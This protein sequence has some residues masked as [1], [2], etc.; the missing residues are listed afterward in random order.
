MRQYAMGRARGPAKAMADAIEPLEPRCMLSFAPVG[1]EI[2]VN[3]FTTSIQ[4]TPAIAV[5]DSGEFVVVWASYGQD[6]SYDGVYAQRYKPAGAPLG[7]EFR[8][9]TTTEGNQHRPAV[10]LD[11]DGDF[12]IVW[13]SLDDESTYGIFAQRF[14]PAG[15]P[16]GSEVLV[17]SYTSS[18]QQYS[19]VAVDGAGNFVVVW[20][21]YGQDGGQYGIYARRYDS[22]GAAQGSEFR[23]NSYT[24]GMQY[25]PDVAMNAAGDFVVTWQSYHQDGDGYGI[26]AKRYNAAGVEQ[27]PPAGAAPG[28]GNEFRVNTFTSSHQRTPSIAM[29]NAGKFAVTWV[30]FDQLVML[31][32][33]IYAQ[34]FDASGMPQGSEFRVNTYTQG[35]QFDPEVAMDNDGDALVVWAGGYDQDGDTYGVFGCRFNATGLRQDGSDFQINTYTIGF[36]RSPT[37]GMTADRNAVVAWSST[38]QDGD[39]YG[40]YAQRYEES[41]A[42]TPQVTAAEFAFD[43]FPQKL[44]FTFDTDASGAVNAGS[45]LLEKIGGGAVPGLTMLPYGTDGTNVATFT[46][47]SSLADGNYQA[48]VSDVGGA[49]VLSFFMLSGDANHDRKV[50]LY[51]LVVIATNWQGTGKTFAQGDFDYN[52]VVN[53]ADL[54]ILATHWQQKLDMPLPNSPILTSARRPTSRS[55]VRITTMTSQLL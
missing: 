20:A 1:G 46:M 11:S 53:S 36:Q 3:T 8:V 52:G 32:S 12:V 29:D 34:R 15:D 27:T 19:A 39:D 25:E 51:D 33:E 31:D 41:A 4:S 26:F 30:G 6:G 23:V 7:S 49:N 38:S 37:V 10:A 5:D 18:N 9:N 2:P 55:A 54:G 28:E 22:A 50:D 24:T 45:I 43:T 13:E 42:A 40:I 17:N 35:S 47:N 14:G 44:R 21:S 48:T 16:L